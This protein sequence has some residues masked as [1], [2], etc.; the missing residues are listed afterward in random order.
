[1]ARRFFRGH[2]WPLRYAAGGSATPLVY[3]TPQPGRLT[4][5][6]SWPP[7]CRVLR[8]RPAALVPRSASLRSG[9]PWPPLRVA[10]MPAALF[11]LR[12]V[13]APPYGS[14]IHSPLCVISS[15]TSVPAASSDRLQSSLC[16][17][18]CFYPPPPRSSHRAG[19]RL[20]L[21]SIPSRWSTLDRTRAP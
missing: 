5:R 9:H 6:P 8:R 21:P 10:S 14:F 3:F 19:T 18:Q 20:E 17:A 13:R 1:M 16:D 12:G 2:P 7:L 11:F 15:S 4:L